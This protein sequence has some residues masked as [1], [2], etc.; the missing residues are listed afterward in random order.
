MKTATKKK[1]KE[2]LLAY[3]FLLPSLIV[4]GIF[5]FWP[6]GF[7]FVLSFFK[8]DFRN[9]NAPYFNGLDNYISIFEFD[10]PPKYSFFE[11]FI[12]SIGYIL[13]AILIVI[14]FYT[15]ITVFSKKK[16]IFLLLLNV[17]PIILIPF[18]KN[19]NFYL[20]IFFD[21]VIFILVFY[22]F[23]NR[24]QM[25]LYRNYTWLNVAAIIFTYVMIEASKFNENGLLN[26]FMDAKDKNLFVKALV[27][28]FYYVILTVPITLAISLFLA[29]L[30]NSNIRFKVFFRTS[31]FI[32]FV[33]SVVA[34]SLVWKWIFNDEFGL[35]NYFL[36]W[37]GIEPIRWLKDEKWTIPTIAIV[38]I[39][40]QIGYDAII[41]LAGL[42][43]IDQFYYEAAE[44]DGANSWHK[45]SKITWPL[46][47]PTTFFLL[48]VSMIGAFKVFAQVYV[49]YDGLP[50]PYNNSGMTMVYYV[51]DLF[52]RQ[53]RMGIASAAAY[54]L[55]G[56]I[57]IFTA[58]QYKVGNKVV[59]YVS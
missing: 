21:I 22:N 2:S 20:M 49:L 36:S 12:F 45:F 14:T 56:I 38:S 35:L 40:K 23:K 30:L 47:S 53:Q 8:W 29:V 39:W 57:L 37:F 18:F 31:Y 28:T 33:T 25:R 46:L 51:F 1:L 11:S 41:F 24:E 55:F 3:L 42:Q 34:V 6:V 5:V 27:N 9:M 32:P 44:V 4:L 13:I 52:Y 26:F 58:I 16:N 59:E 43:N 19:M 10:Y 17:I 48:I 54:L 7:S 15:L 50:G